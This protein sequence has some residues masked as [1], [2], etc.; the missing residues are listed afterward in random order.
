MEAGHQRKILSVIKFASQAFR[1]DDGWNV[2][3]NGSADDLTHGRLPSQKHV[4]G[5]SR[6][7]AEHNRLDP[8]YLT[9]SRQPMR[10]DLFTCPH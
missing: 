8:K 5:Y 1:H 6:S 2:R 7:F 9:N 3:D 4:G 10:R